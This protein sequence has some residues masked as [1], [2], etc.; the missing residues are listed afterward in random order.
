MRVVVG[1]DDAIA[2]GANLVAEVVAA[3]PDATLGFATGA[4]PA[5][6]YAELARRRQAGLVDFSRAHAVALDEYLGLAPD[7]ADSYAHQLH[8]EVTGPLG[9]AREHCDFLRGDAPDPDEECVR[10]ERV[11]ARGVDLQVLGI[12][13]NGHIAFNEPGTD[14]ASRTRVVQL[15]PSTRQ[16]NRGLLS[17]LADT[18]EAALSQG[19]GT[20][21]EARRILLIARGAA[22]AEAL[23][24]ALRGP[25]DPACPASAL[26]LHDDVTVIAD[27]EAAAGLAQ[28]GAIR[29][30]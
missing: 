11:L 17:T 5:P 7:H 8:R 13:R 14:V 25:V 16:A 19:V 26:Q 4:T 3:R 6:L 18:P 10:Y 23:E 2:T 20:I 15:A 9:I 29:S 30:T 21:L 22:K 12:G 27:E 28:A 24:R 1:A